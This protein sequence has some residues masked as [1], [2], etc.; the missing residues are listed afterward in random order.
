MKYRIVWLSLAVLLAA[1]A[2]AP[3][4]SGCAPVGR[5]GQLCLLPPSALPAVDASHVVTVTRA[6]KQDTFLGRL[7]I[8]A[9]ALRLAGFSLFGTNLF[10]LEYDGQTIT[11]H[12]EQ[13]SLHPE[14]LV[15]MLEIALADPAALQ[16]RLHHLTLTVNESGD[17]QTRE[18]FESGH[19]IARIE[20]TGRPLAA[21]RIRIAIPPANLSV[22]LTPLAD[23]AGPP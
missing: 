4:Q 3:P 13:M 8:D 17:M 21:A 6:G 11:H 7:H 14:L 1:C 9:R 15:V 5:D 16:S 22:Q 18:L 2:S 12:P 10:T 23:T 19:L 20:E